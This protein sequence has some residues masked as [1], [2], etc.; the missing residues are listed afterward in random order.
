MLVTAPARRSSDDGPGRRLQAR[1][2]LG[3][4][5]DRH[6]RAADRAADAITGSP[7]ATHRLGAGRGGGAAAPPSV[8][9]VV[10]SPGHSLDP[11]TRALLEPRFGHDFGQVRVHTDAAAADS[12]RQIDA[13]AYTVGHDMVFGAGEYRP[14]SRDG[15][16]LLAHELAHVVQQ[17]AGVASPG[18]VQRDDKDP[19]KRKEA[20]K[21][22]DKPAAVWSRKL[23][24]GP[25]LLDGD[26]P[27][28]QVVF[29]HVLPAV[30]K[31]ARQVWQVV[32]VTQTVLTDACEEKTRKTH[33]ID[34]VDIGSRTTVSD[35]WNWIRRDALCVALEANTA[36]IG[37]DDRKSNFSE[38]SEEVTDR[39]AGS[40]LKTMTGP[41]GTYSG[42][43]S[44]V[45]AANCKD[46]P[47]KVK[48]LQKKHKLPDGEAL[49][50]DGVGSW[51]K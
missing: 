30:P 21:A 18:L 44:F 2:R 4:P 11:A 15:Q 28:Y 35:D 41:K 42:T 23:T 16:R 25:R 8:E 50:I 47:D 43:Y 9:H 24:G 6:E 39:L 49:A 31:G 26:R 40:V 14:G 27:S 48:A 36:T 51:P 10:S 46:C 32:E 38:Q 7:P 29:D 5:G 17:R 13:R 3:Q 22:Q 33:V 19:G 45:K 34:V 37:F 12:A 1:L 20:D